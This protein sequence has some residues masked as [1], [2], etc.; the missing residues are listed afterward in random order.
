[1]EHVAASL[2]FPERRE[3]LQKR[4]FEASNHQLIEHETGVIATI[5]PVLLLCFG[6]CAAKPDAR[7]T[8]G[9]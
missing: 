8:C 6:F 5:T 7:N 9:Q 4:R 1:V 2:Y 3:G